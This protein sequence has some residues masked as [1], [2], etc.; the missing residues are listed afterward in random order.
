MKKDV[1]KKPK[2]NVRD[3]VFFI[4]NPDGFFCTHLFAATPVIERF[5]ELTGGETAV[6]P[7]SLKIAPADYASSLKHHLPV[8]LVFPKEF[9]GS[10]RI[11]YPA[12]QVKAVAGGKVKDFAGFIERLYEPVTACLARLTG[13]ETG[14]VIVSAG[15]SE[16]DT[17]RKDSSGLAIWIKY[18]VEISGKAEFFVQQAVFGSLFASLRDH[19]LGEK[20]GSAGYTDPELMLDHLRA[21][22]RHFQERLFS[23]I[24]SSPG[25]AVSLDGAGGDHAVNLEEL[26]IVPDRTIRAIIEETVRKRWPVK[27][28]VYALEGMSDE[29]RGRF[30]QN[31][32]RNHR[33]E[34]RGGMRLWEA[35]KDEQ[36]QAMRDLA[37]I[38]VG[39]LE[40]GDFTLD[41]RI[42]SRLEKMIR[43]MDEALARSSLEYIESGTFGA[44]MKP[45]N[46]V[47]F[48]ILI[49]RVGR[50]VLI[51]AFSF[52]D[53][54][55][56]E[57]MNRNVTPFARTLLE[58][59]IEHWRRKTPEKNE[60]LTSAAAAQRAVIRRAIQLKRELSRM[61]F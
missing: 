60:R 36:T 32:S 54:T 27:S 23:E 11:F 24:E 20:G 10:T 13:A 25:G 58:E 7:V 22:N 28:F 12:K 19:F 52:A 61:P 43:D 48:Q 45:L 9:P 30:L 8:M 6:T 49:R 44:S 1:R 3:K 59:D 31:L 39:M 57:K 21:V 18:H 47:V 16:A 51:Q 56:I 29:L 35:G 26:R 34:V 5:R 15:L 46:D 38:I 2:G 55:I 33:K 17:A 41:K 42:R 4:K 40:K 37:W 14:K 50:K 53:E